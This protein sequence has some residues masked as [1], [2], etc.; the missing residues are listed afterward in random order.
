MHQM[1]LANIIDREY[2]WIALLVYDLIAMA[3]I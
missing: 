1:Y 2:K 3:K